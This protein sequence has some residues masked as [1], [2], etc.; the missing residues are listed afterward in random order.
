MPA[1][2]PTDYTAIYVLVDPRTRK[3]RY[4]GKS[5]NPAARYRSHC[6]DPVS[7]RRDKITR[8]VDEL[9]ACGLRPRMR[10]L[11]W[12]EDWET[13]EREVIALCRASGRDMLNTE[14]GGLVRKHCAKRPENNFQT[15]RNCM[16]DLA[17][18]A[19]KA[20]RDGNLG[21]YEARKQKIEGIRALVR[22]MTDAQ[23][24]RFYQ[25]V[26]ERFGYERA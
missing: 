15:F 24:A 4:A 3:I 12:V 23:L 5:N 8:W 20:K 17:R 2:R 13:A 10:V 11:R 18:H 9:R 16:A 21:L 25:G 19:N 1:G 26:H 7:R 22:A 14:D 6:S